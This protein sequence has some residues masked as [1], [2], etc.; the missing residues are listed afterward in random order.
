MLLEGSRKAKIPA[1]KHQQKAHD[2]AH[3][4]SAK[5]NAVARD[6]VFL[7]FSRSVMTAGRVGRRSTNPC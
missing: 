6:G 5:K 2:F 3:K 4:V 7:R 1:G